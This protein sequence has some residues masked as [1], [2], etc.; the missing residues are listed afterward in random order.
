MQSESIGK[1]ADA[2]AK[3]QAE[4]K[5]PKKGKTAKLGTYSYSYADLA[6]IIEAY[7]EPLSK[8]G[9][10]LAQT[11]RWQDN[12]LVLVTTLLHSSGEWLSSEYPLASYPKPQEQGSAITYAR[13]YNVTA[14]LGIA[15]EDDDD[16]AAAQTGTPR[17]AAEKP[18]PKPAN[19]ER[20]ST[21]DIEKVHLA[22]KKAGLKSAAE[23]APVLSRILPG[24]EKASDMSPKDLRVV[25]EALNGMVR[26]SVSA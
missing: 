25:L 5:A 19:G 15:A 13:R 21:A 16:G 26:E 20:L 10:A 1:L 11:M 23:L 3:A 8:N 14:L 6:D 4:I 24:V 22:A 7:R 9:L 12:H 17:A 18:A 2:L